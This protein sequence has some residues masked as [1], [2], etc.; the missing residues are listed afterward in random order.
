[1][2]ESYRRVREQ[3][4]ARFGEGM[5]CRVYVAAGGCGSSLGAAAILDKM[6][7]EVRGQGV[8]ARV[9][10]AGCDGACFE[11]PSI[12]VRHPDGEL[13]RFAKVTVE[14]VSTIVK[15]WLVNDSLGG[16]WEGTPVSW[17]V[18]SETPFWRG[19]RRLVASQI[20]RIDPADID[21]Y[22]AGGGYSA[23][24]AVLDEVSSAGV[25]DAVKEADLRGRGGAYFPAG[26]KWEG[27]RK[28]PAPRHLVVN[29]EEG[30]P[31]AFKDRHLLEGDPHRPLEGAL[32]A[33]YAVGVA[34]IYF[35]VN[36][37]AR[38]SATRL[39]EA[40]AQARE[41]GMVGASVLGSDFNVEVE[42]RRGA[43]GYVCGEESVILESIEGKLPVPRLKP[44]FPTEAGLW[45]QPTVINNVETLANVPLIWQEQG[46]EVAKVAST[47]IICLSGSIQRPGLVEVELGT[48][49]RGV[50]FDI[51]GGA[52]EGRN[53]KG[54][55]AGGPSGGLLPESAL[56]VEARPGFLHETGAVLG[57]GG[58]V[59]LDDTASIPEVVR[60]LTDYNAR[61]S[62]GKCTPCREGTPR[63]REHLTLM[64][65]D[66]A[67]NEDMEAVIALNSVIA[68]ASLC[69]L[70]QMAPNPVKS[71]LYQFPGDFE[72]RKE[73]TQARS[74]D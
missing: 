74:E 68:G 9:V 8:N 24:A 3:A 38:R 13:L 6:R 62:C 31:G 2:S 36:G 39:E 35:Y 63:L 40:I 58:V 32:I 60:R 42:V 23:L 43:G 26:V 61:E 69:G 45:G 15:E 67:I 49:Y 66:K 54:V 19:Q 50:V 73:S 25:V 41:R 70:G 27:A 10:E 11:S 33:A 5:G 34:R 64:A 28:F 14:S 65:D 22:I 16:E 52:P 44:P 1:M 57:S 17:A 4:E 71:A 46:R 37:Q 20:G 47:K 7:G 72:V 56:E 48:P 12:W 59:V 29:A 21:E 55:L 30:E 18:Q 51:G 53:V